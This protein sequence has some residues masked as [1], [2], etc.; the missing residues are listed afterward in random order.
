VT[1]PLDIACR[2]IVEMVTDYLDGALDAAA[3]AAFEWHLADCPHCTVYLEQIRATVAAAGRVEVETLSA[4]TKAALLA[5]FRD[6]PRRAD[7]SGA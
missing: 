3:T 4:G 5:A 7:R 2:E 6:L 1:D